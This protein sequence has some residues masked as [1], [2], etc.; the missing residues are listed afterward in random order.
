VRNDHFTLRDSQIDFF[1]PGFD[2][3]AIFNL[4]T[5]SPLA[6]SN[7]MTGTQQQKIRIYRKDTNCL[8]WVSEKLAFPI[9]HPT[10]ALF[11]SDIF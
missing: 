7:L 3:M 4:I 11:P 6:E 9:Q 1:F 5:S 8:I 2:P 10:P